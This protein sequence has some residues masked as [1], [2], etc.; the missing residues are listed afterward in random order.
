MA[1]TNKVT[2]KKRNEV[3]QQNYTDVLFINQV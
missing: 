3:F 1:N 2:F